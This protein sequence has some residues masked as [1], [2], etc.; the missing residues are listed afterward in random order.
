MAK[1]SVR[2]RNGSLAPAVKANLRGLLLFQGHFL[3]LWQWWDKC[4][5]GMTP[6]VPP[7]PAAPRWAHRW[8]PLPPFPGVTWGTHVALRALQPPFPR[9]T[10]PGSSHLFPLRKHLLPTMEGRW[11]HPKFPI[12]HF[13]SVWDYFSTSR[14]SKQSSAECPSNT[15][16]ELRES[17]FPTLLR[18]IL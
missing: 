14:D 5:I 7:C 10:K 11:S 18:S 4:G 12:T 13:T 3:H 2:L 17:L 1:R 8:V 6:V 16:C 15:F 9:L